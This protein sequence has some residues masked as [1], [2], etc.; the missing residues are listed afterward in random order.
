MS[1]HQVEA[2]YT[3]SQAMERGESFCPHVILTDIGL[4]DIDGYQLAQRVRATSWGSGT[5]LV[6]I[7]GWDEAEHRRQPLA[8]LFSHHLTK[9]IDPSTIESLLAQI[10]T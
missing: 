2:V 1:G 5:V 6:A 9:P 7:T 10:R 8:P 4:P 3:G